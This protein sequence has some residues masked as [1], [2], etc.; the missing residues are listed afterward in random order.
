MRFSPW[1]SLSTR[2]KASQNLSLIERR[3]LAVGGVEAG[4]DFGTGA[5][6]GLAEAVERGLD[7]VE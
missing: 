5:E 4:E 3:G 6:L 2:E 7:S 1:S